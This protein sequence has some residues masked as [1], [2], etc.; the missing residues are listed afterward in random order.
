LPSSP[1]NIKSKDFTKTLKYIPTEFLLY[2]S[3]VS[4]YCG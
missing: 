3:L 2:A 1:I 4:D